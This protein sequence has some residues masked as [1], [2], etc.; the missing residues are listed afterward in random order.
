MNKNDTSSKQDIIIS[1]MRSLYRLAELKKMNS[2]SSLV[3]NEKNILMRYLKSLE[4]EDILFISMNFNTY[5]DRQCAQTAL[6]DEKLAKS[7]V[8]YINSMN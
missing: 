4:A 5:Y 8:R 6:D 7:F 2:P 3:D 1:T